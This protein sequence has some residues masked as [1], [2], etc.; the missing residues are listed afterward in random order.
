[1]GQFTDGSD[2][3]WVTWVMGQ[4]SDGSGGSWIKWVIGQFTD[5]SDGSWVTW[6]MGQF[7][8]GS[9]GS[10]VTKFNPLSPLQTLESN[11]NLAYET[12]FPACNRSIMAY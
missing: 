7:T 3:S 10:L 9:D 11:I 8:D 6:V 2:G 4:L 1:M 12:R 5:G